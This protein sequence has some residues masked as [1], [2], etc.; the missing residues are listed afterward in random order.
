[1]TRALPGKNKNKIIKQ[2]KDTNTIPA[3]I[4]TLDLESIKEL[5]RTEMKTMKDSS[6]TQSQT[7]QR[8]PYTNYNQY[9]SQ[10]K[11][12][13]GQ[14]QNRYNRQYNTN[15]SGCYNCGD[16]THYKQDCPKLSRSNTV[17][18]NPT[19]NNQALN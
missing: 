13:T 19:F 18:T 8:Q 4:D 14:Y 12:N 9:T 3:S 1:M 11:Q 10:Y 16:N 7:D 17:Q 15:K 5:I 2:N 6:Q